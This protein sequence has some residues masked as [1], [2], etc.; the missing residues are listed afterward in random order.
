MA[1]SLRG[2]ITTSA[3]QQEIVRQSI[4]ATHIRIDNNIGLVKAMVEASIMKGSST[5]KRKAIQAA[6]ETPPGKFE[7]VFSSLLSL[8]ND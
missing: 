3:M 5:K 4:E 1:M 8:N 6:L 7:T 2:I